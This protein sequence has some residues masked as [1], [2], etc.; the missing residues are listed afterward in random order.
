MAKK[1]AKIE[2]TNKKEPK[3]KK[4]PFK[5]FKAELKKVIWP[6]PKQLSSSTAAVISI[7]LITGVI[8]IVL[9]FS[10]N[11][12]NK[13]G[14]NKLQVKLRKKNNTTVSNEITTSENNDEASS[15]ENE[16]AV[17]NEVQE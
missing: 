8:L 2:K 4:H 9:D 17:N 15:E 16:T 1:E 14:I 12:I 3:N 13:Y 10:F 11:A 7:V 5:G 6:T